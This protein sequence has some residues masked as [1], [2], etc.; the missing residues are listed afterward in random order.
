M[1]WLPA[2]QSGK[3]SARQNRAEQDSQRAEPLPES[4][5]SSRSLMR[6]CR[7]GIFWE[8]GGVVNSNSKTVNSGHFFVSQPHPFP[9]PGFLRPRMR[10]YTTAQ[11]MMAATMIVCAM[12]FTI[13]QMKLAANPEKGTLDLRCCPRP[14]AAMV[15][16]RAY[17]ESH[18]FPAPSLC[19]EVIG[20]DAG[21]VQSSKF[22]VLSRATRRA[23]PE[24]SRDFHRACGGLNLEL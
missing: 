10:R 18:P 24:Q 4:V 12:S 14:R 17:T 9:Q 7:V 19:G 5:R 21:N 13:V 23:V 8:A 6:G 16:L 15:F 22:E 3:R 11:R 1:S 20:G 2:R